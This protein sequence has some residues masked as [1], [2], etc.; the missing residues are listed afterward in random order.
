MVSPSCH[1]HADDQS[2]ILILLISLLL[3]TKEPSTSM[4]Q[5]AP[6]HHMYHSMNAEVSPGLHRCR[7]L[8]LS[9][10]ALRICIRDI[11]RH[12]RLVGLCL[13]YPLLNKSIFGHLNDR[14]TLSGSQ[15]SKLGPRCPAQ[16]NVCIAVAQN[17]AHLC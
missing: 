14:R 2:Y 11:V 12:L 1:P 3:S 16:Q 7:R 15:E 5:G 4:V 6:V 17:S 8:H 10:L 13:I 9:N